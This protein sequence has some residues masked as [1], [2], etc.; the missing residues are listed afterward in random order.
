MIIPGTEAAEPWQQ[1]IAIV[2]F[3]VGTGVLAAVTQWR[4]R[5]AAIK[6]EEAK[7][8]QVVATAGHMLAVQPT[9]DRMTQDTLVQTLA[10]LTLAVN[11]L[12]DRLEEDAR[13]QDAEEAAR[14]AFDALELKRMVE[15]LKRMRGPP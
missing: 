1:L 2:A 9:A 7:V 15:E 8:A 5:K 12:I 3:M 6:S 13:E 4:G 11:K 14:Q 10:S